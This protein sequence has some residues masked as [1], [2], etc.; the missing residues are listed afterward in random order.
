MVSVIVIHMVLGAQK[1]RQD[2]VPILPEDC[3][4]ADSG[5]S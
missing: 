1:H 5:W 2:A 4:F 3:Q